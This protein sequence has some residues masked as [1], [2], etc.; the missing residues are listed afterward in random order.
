[1]KENI[2]T[3]SKTTES[4]CEPNHAD[5]ETNEEQEEKDVRARALLERPIEVGVVL[6]LLV[7]RKERLSRKL[8][9]WI[10]QRAHIGSDSRSTTAAHVRLIC[11]KNAQ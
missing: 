4:Q 8:L 2:S 9:S 6:A 7:L 10:E 1:M 11:S 3:K 5:P